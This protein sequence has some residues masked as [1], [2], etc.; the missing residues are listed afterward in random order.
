MR[1]LPQRHRVAASGISGLEQRHAWMRTTGYGYS[2]SPLMGCSAFPS[3]ARAS[4]LSRPR[5]ESV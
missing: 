5:T 4:L 2:G 3:G 1:A